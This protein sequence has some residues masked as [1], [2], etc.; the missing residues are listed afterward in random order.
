MRM[1]WLNSR[2]LSV[3][4]IGLTLTTAAA[5]F[6]LFKPS[7]APALCRV[8]DVRV[9]QAARIPEALRYAQLD[10]AR[11]QFG[12]GVAAIEAWEGL[13]DAVVVAGRAY[14]RSTRRG[15]HRVGALESGRFFQTTHMIYVPRAVPAQEFLTVDAGTR[16][17]KLWQQ[18]SKRFPRGVLVAGP[19]H[20]QQLH[21]YA[22]NRPAI[23]GLSIPEHITHYY[24]Q[25]MQ[26]SSQT[27]TYLVGIAASADSQLHFI[28]H[29]HGGEL[30]LP[31]HVLVLKSAPANTAN[32]PRP[33][34]AVAVGRA[35]GNSQLASARLALYPLDNLGACSDAFAGSAPS[36]NH[37]QNV[38]AP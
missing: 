22:I 32:T 25:P 10:A 29:R 35:A 9:L 19:V 38:I 20:W 18:L 17:D 1:S 4:V 13:G 28:A 6:F 16:L 23:E 21:H 2:R 31:R 7:S 14:V 12:V 5:G 30:D 11:M 15:T 36:T 8:G 34:D 33:Q 26:T 27:W 37:S 3:L 24:T